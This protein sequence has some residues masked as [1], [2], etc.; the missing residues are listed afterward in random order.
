M[1]RIAVVDPLPVFRIGMVSVLA[2]DGYAVDTP[3]DVLGW[4]GAADRPL[5]VLT[6]WSA[7]SWAALAD[8][9]A[10]PAVLVVALLDDLTVTTAVRAARAGAAGVLDRSAPADGVRRAVLAAIGGDAVLPR[11]ALAALAASTEPDAS[12]WQRPSEAQLGWLRDL[13][14]GSTVARI[15]ANTGYSERAMFRLLQQLYAQLGARSRTEALMKAQQ[16]GWLRT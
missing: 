14:A 2:Q 3:D 15:A 8:L 1:Q 7:Q 16:R 6:V 5:V 13:A 10:M 4:V 11:P 9:A 12:L